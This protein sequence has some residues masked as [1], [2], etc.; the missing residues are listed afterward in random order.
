MVWRFFSE[1][2]RR[3]LEV[4]EG[5]AAY[6]G[7]GREAAERV[8]LAFPRLR[9]IVY[10]ADVGTSGAVG[11]SGAKGLRYLS[12][13]LVKIMKDA[14]SATSVTTARTTRL[15]AFLASA[16]ASIMSTGAAWR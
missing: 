7:D 3:E 15:V 8:R 1:L 5:E 9:A 10:G 6:V 2:R 13:L 16:S 12:S 11:G 14:A 4:S